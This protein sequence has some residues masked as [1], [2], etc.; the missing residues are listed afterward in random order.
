MLTGRMHALPDTWRIVQE[1][2]AVTLPLAP[3]GEYT[4]A[5]ALES[6]IC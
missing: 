3:L 5:A 4:E 2:N 6:Q 1:W